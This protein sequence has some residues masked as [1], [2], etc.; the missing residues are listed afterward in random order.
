MGQ[1]LKPRVTIPGASQNGKRR[2][3]VAR[4]T[5]GT[6]GSAENLYPPGRCAVDAARGTIEIAFDNG[7]GAVSGFLL[8]PSAVSLPAVVQPLSWVSI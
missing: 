4:E 5:K 8:L 7:A 3:C 2:S 1:E 6:A